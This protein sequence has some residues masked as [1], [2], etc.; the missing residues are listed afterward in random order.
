MFPSLTPSAADTAIAITIAGMAAA[1]VFSFGYMLG[2]QAINK[3]WAAWSI[4]HG[5]GWPPIPKPWPRFDHYK[6][7][8][9]VLRTPI[10]NVNK[11]W[12]D[13]KEVPVDWKPN[14]AYKR[15]DLFVNH[16][17]KVQIV[18]GGYQPDIPA[19]TVPEPPHVGSSTVVPRQPKPRRRRK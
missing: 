3:Q 1:A 9:I 6:T 5:F 10:V 19:G 12:I 17:G 2:S 13:G 8:S 11:V 4:R 15:G 14:T 7:S 18:T 16:D